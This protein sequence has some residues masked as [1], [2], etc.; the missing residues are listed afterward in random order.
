MSEQENKISQT[1]LQ[2]LQQHSDAEQNA[3]IT[4]W[5]EQNQDSFTPEL[6]AQGLQI[7]TEILDLNP[8]SEMIIAALCLASAESNPQNSSKFN[9]APGAQWLI[10]KT[11]KLC[12]IEQ[13]NI[14]NEF[15][16]SDRKQKL[17]RYALL[18][19][20]E[21]IRAIP[22]VLAKRLYDLNALKHTD[23]KQR[24]QLAEQTLSIYTP[25]AN[26]MGFGNLKWK[27]E[28]I[29]LYC[30]QPDIY[31]NLREVLTLRRTEREQLVHEYKSKISAMLTDQQISNFNINGRAKHMMSIYK[32]MQR[33][34]LPA[35]QLY[36]TLA[37]RILLPR[38]KDCYIALSLIH[39]SWRHFKPE[40]DDYIANPKPNGYQS[41]HTVIFTPENRPIE[42][43]LRT[44]EMHDS[45]EHGAQAHWAYKEGNNDAGKIKSLRQVISWQQDLNPNLSE[46]IYVFTPQGNIIELPRGAT[47]IDFAY[48]IHTQVGHRCKG[49]K[50]NGNLI[51]LTQQLRTGD[52]IEIITAKEDKPSRDWLRPE[53]NYIATAGAR[54][55]I[56]HWFRTQTN[57]ENIGKGQSIWDD[58]ART[59]H[60]SQ[61]ELKTL[62]DKLNLKDKKDL[63]RQLGS[64]EIS[65]HTLKN[66][67]AAA[68]AKDTTEIVINPSK[69]A[70][71]TSGIVSTDINNLLCVYAK[72]CSPVPGDLIHGY[73]TQS[74][75]V[76]V[77]RSDCKE[78]EHLLLVHPERDINIDW[79]TNIAT[80]QFVAE[81]FITVHD[82]A[83]ILRDISTCLAAEKINMTSI[84]TKSE[85][86]G[87]LTIGASIQVNNYSILQN[88]IKLIGSIPD[89][90]SVTRS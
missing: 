82:R 4:N 55:K 80:Q 45:A 65:L 26:R 86:N 54:Q 77:H 34:T 6:L 35:D 84:S 49:A 1:W 2:Q 7:A 79:G 53:L 48:H 88:I 60:W 40:F 27:L 75:G 9:I 36:D 12:S 58:I 25:L 70:K 5:L 64:G 41:I 3:H 68:E 50:V 16:Q 33:K 89:V 62:T 73:I 61:S 76:S 14:N 43:Q 20:A 87:P 67:L 30:K 51:A 8:D 23:T 69:I 28:D 52:K 59:Q 90:I 11:L 83:G 19:I 38:V 85:G 18:E 74:K 81:I 66:K 29:C 13:S 78:L 22:I 44:Y 63:W 46:N 32:K 21:D 15:A 24:Q 72:C 31:K 57:L 56:N 17:L 42:I 39:K 37:L 47:A 10:D 71:K